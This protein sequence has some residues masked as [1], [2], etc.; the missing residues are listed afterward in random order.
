M[1]THRLSKSCPVASWSSM[2][3]L[4][5]ANRHWLFL[6]SCG[7]SC[8]GLPSA[9]AALEHLQTESYDIIITDLQMPAMD[10]FGVCPV[11]YNNDDTRC[12]DHHDHG[13]RECADRCTSDCVTVRLII[14]KNHSRLINSNNR[15][16]RVGT[17]SLVGSTAV[18]T[19]LDSEFY[20]VVDRF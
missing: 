7:H 10:G 19:S 4:R 16:T 14:L 18:C 17:W 9:I 11:A 8:T 3:M 15:R 12:T 1:H 13:S 5:R 6:Q 20:T 2:I